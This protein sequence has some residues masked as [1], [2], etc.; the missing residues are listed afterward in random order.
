[1]VMVKL[2]E[3]PANMQVDFL[4]ESFSAVMP[5]IKRYGAKVLYPA[6]VRKVEDK[7][8]YYPVIVDYTGQ[9]LD[10]ED[11]FIHASYAEL[12]KHFYGPAEVQLEQQLKLTFARHQYAVKLAFP[13]S[14]DEVITAV[15][16]FEDVKAQFWSLIDAACSFVGKA[17]KDL[18]ARFNA[19]EMAAWAF[20]NGMDAA[21]VEYFSMQFAIVSLNLLQNGRYW[22][23]LF[24]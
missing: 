21:Q 6:F 18:P 14:A 22:D 7:F 4:V 16:R 19:E 8:A 15:K 10:D 5:E 1:M 11:K 12:R 24:S 17:R 13:K 9:D 20:A 2:R 23:E 3:I